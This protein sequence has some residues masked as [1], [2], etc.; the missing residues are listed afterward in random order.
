MKFRL[1][2]YDRELGRLLDEFVDAQTIEDFGGD[3]R[4]AREAVG[5]LLG[6][7]WGDVIEVGEG[8]WL[9][10]PVHPDEIDR[11][12]AIAREGK[13]RGESITALADAGKFD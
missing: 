2:T 7:W 13:A 1:A 6:I 11:R 9:V 8:G 5:A 3:D 4:F 10:T 12:L